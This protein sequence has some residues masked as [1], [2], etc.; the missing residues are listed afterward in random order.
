MKTE[1][2]KR[3]SE[4]HLT[5]QGEHMKCL[6]EI[7]TCR[8][9]QKQMVLQLK[10]LEPAVSHDDKQYLRLREMEKLIREHES[11]LENFE[12]AILQLERNINDHMS[13]LMQDG[14]VGETKSEMLRDHQESQSHHIKQL[15]LFSKFKSQHQKRKELIQNFCTEMKA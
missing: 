5:W 10:E 8:Q 4:D 11:D 1:E 9:E 13:V 3:I 2:Q 15:G 7:R 12:T 14:S 6:S